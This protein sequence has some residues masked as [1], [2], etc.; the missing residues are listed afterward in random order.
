MSLKQQ[1]MSD[2]KQAMKDK[3]KDRLTLIR[4][5]QSDVKNAEIREKTELTDEQIIGVVQ[6]SLKQTKESLDFYEKAGTNPSEIEKHKKWIDVLQEYLPK[7]LSEDEVRAFIQ[8]AIQSNG[9]SGKQ[10]MRKLMP[11]IMPK[12][13][14]KIDGSVVSRLAGEEISK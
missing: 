7:P 8:E 4:M 6:K 2:M 1:L 13:K 9:L 14:G 5:V 3:D 11:L 12:V 10:D